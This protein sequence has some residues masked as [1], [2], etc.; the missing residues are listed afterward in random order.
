[1][2]RP[3]KQNREPFW[4]TERDCWYVHH[5]SRTVRLSPDKDEAWRLWHELMARPPEPE[6]KLAPGPDVQAVEILDA[7][8]DWCQKHKAPRT[9]DWYR[10]FYRHL[11]A[12]L[13]PALKVVD[14]KPFHLTRAQEARP[15]W[16]NNTRNDFVT[17]VKRAFN[18]AID[19]ELIERN[20]IARAKKPAREAREMV[21]L[22]SEYAEI[23]GAI[24]EPNFRDLIEFSWETGTRPQEIS[25]I[26]AR[27]FDADNGRIIFPP[28][29]AKGKKYYRI[30]YLTPRA[31]EIIA[32]LAEERPQGPLMVNS[33]GQPWTKDAINCAFRRLRVTLGLRIMK[34]KGDDREKLPR[35][36]KWDVEAGRL[37]EARKEHRE[38]LKQRRKEIRKRAMELSKPYHLGA[39][40][41]GYATEALKAGV[42][43]VSLAHLM[44]HRDPSMIPKV[45]GQVQQ[46]PE[47]MASAARRAK[48]VKDA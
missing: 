33:E 37:A 46:D 31:R 43:V 30:I 2:G 47:H 25:R 44:G 32:R 3:K 15:D 21:V 22:P 27:L 1:M 45:Y 19:E 24:K 39:F 36:R 12:T 9:Y 26:E 42:D 13:P 20:P 38:K 10:D 41:K 28:R 7:F 8:L 17:A 4:R 6:P 16:S 40:R 34:A 23:I 35:F 18:W 5:G 14:L 11:A 29:E 48:R